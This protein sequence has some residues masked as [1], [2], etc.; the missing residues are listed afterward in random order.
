MAQDVGEV[1]VKRH[2]GST[3]GGGDT[4]HTLVIRTRQLLITHEGHVVSGY[5][6]DSRDAVGDILVELHSRHNQAV[7]GTILSRAK[8][9]AYANAAG[10]ASLGNVG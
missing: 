5:S 9:A 10:I 1:A 3:F 6:K 7:T 4:E 2:E 8:S